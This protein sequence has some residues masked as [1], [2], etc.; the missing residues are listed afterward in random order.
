M[1]GLCSLPYEA[2]KCTQFADEMAFG[3][4]RDSKTLFHSAAVC[5]NLPG[6]P[7]YDPTLP[8]VSCLHADG[9]LASIVRCYVDD[10][11][12]VGQSCNDAGKPH[13]LW[14]VFTAFWDCK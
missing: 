3:D 10:I 5:L 2:I 6:S 13:I 11:R 1:M 4:A 14:L 12:P 8:W 7:S 9:S